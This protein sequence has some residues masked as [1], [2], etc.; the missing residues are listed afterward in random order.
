MINKEFFKKLNPYNENI[1]EDDIIDNIISNNNWIKEPEF[2]QE[3]G[4]G[5]ETYMVCY[6]ISEEETPDTHDTQGTAMELKIEQ[7]FL[8]THDTNDNEIWSNITDYFFE[9]PNPKLEEL[10]Y[11]SHINRFN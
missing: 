4:L 6:D 1:K 3:Y 10:L 9:Y 7:I 5:S 8:L 2:I 11:E